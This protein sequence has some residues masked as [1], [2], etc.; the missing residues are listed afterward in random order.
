MSTKS[1]SMR[2]MRALQY[3]LLLFVCQATLADELTGIVM[4]EIS[5]LKDATG[6][7]YIAVYDSD[8]TWLGD[9]AVMNKKVVIAESLDGELVRTELQ[10]PLGSYALSAFYD[11]DNDGEMDTS[12]IGMPKEPIALSNNAVAKFGPPSFDDAVFSVGAEPVI[13]RMLMRDM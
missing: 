8:A 11:K 2:T 12:F 6:N 1:H 5:G 13:Q 9:E 7:V 10:V 4:V 3:L